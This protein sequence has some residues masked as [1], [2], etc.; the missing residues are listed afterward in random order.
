MHT[1][2]LF[3]MRTD[4]PRQ[5]HVDTTSK[6]LLRYTHHQQLRLANV[7]ALQ[8]EGDQ[9]SYTTHSQVVSKP[10]SHFW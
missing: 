10:A 9:V 2:G 4:I 3:I 7:K 1:L 8:K 6:A 5:V